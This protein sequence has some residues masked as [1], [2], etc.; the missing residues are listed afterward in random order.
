MNGWWG[1]LFPNFDNKPYDQSDRD[2]ILNH[3]QFFRQK[4][5]A[6]EQGDY[7][8]VP[9]MNKGCQIMGTKTDE[10]GLIIG[11]SKFHLS[12]FSEEDTL[13]RYA[14]HGL[15]GEL[16]FETQD[17]AE[18][19][20]QDVMFE[21]DGADFGIDSH[22]IYDHEWIETIKTYT[23]FA[24]DHFMFEPQSNRTIQ[25]IDRYHWRRLT[26]KSVDPE[27]R[28]LF[29]KPAFVDH[30]IQDRHICYHGLNFYVYPGAYGEGK[31]SL[32][33]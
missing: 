11:Q 8:F 28:P 32:P 29:F 3:R 10:N 6:K 24:S 31:L 14:Y 27:N 12:T 22:D 9:N 25:S 5:C 30:H 15:R 13:I 2:N 33:V 26:P 18:E 17:L 23:I 4:F 1:R 7:T 21:L 20:E 19:Y 16:R